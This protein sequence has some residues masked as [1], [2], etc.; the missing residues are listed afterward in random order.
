MFNS[1]YR[2]ES[3]D[4]LK[5]SIEK[6]NETNKT[7]IEA[8]ETLFKRRT[9]LKST[10]EEVEEYVNLL[11]NTPKKIVTDVEKI[12]IKLDNYQKILNV[13]E[14]EIKK[15]TVSS[16]TSA[17]ASVVAGV[18]VAAFAPTAAMGIA[19][20]FG[21]ASTGT[22][23]SALSGAAA[24]NAALAWLGGGALVAGGGGVAAGETL[25]TLAGP[26]GWIIGGAGLVGSGLIVNGK[27]KKIAA[28]ANE[29][30]EKVIAQTKVQMALV[31]DIENIC[32][33]TDKNIRI[34]SDYISRVRK[35]FPY[36]YLQMTVDQKKVLGVM[37]NT[38]LAAS[39]SLHSTVGAN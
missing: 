29:K 33:I 9:S 36:D 35:D 27:N 7:V 18:G 1:K 22:A 28:E 11:S 16:S 13:V 4:R 31:K 38:S 37:V 14:E 12:K 30:N 17:A 25:L 3:I 19:T 26:V 2:K 24:S 32:L 34:L 20:T 5:S 8:S 6:F 21:V 15:A 10:L 23:I 39:K